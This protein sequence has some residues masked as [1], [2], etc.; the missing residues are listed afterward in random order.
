MRLLTFL[1]TALVPLLAAALP[2]H[3]GARN[4]DVITLGADTAAAGDTPYQV[5]AVQSL[6]LSRLLTVWEQV[7]LGNDDGNFV[8]IQFPAMCVSQ[9]QLPPE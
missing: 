3:P 2:A 1:A 5:R 9:N 6:S 4:T 8:A 7:T